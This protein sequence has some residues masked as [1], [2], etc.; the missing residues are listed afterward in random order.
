[1]QSHKLTGQ[2]FVFTLKKEWITLLLWLIGL[3]AYVIIGVVA[4]IEIYGEPAELEA[5]AMAMQNPAMEALF[6]KAIGMD[7]FTV[8]ALYTQS[9]TIIGFV[10]IALMSILLVV[11]N[12][13]GEEEDGTLELIQALPV[14]RLAHT[15]ATIILLLATNTVLAIISSVLLLLLGDASMTLHG[16][17]LTGAMYGISGILFGAVALIT[18]QLSSNTRGSMM[19]AFSVLG[20]AYILRIIG[21]A[22]LT[23]LSWISP[24][25]LLYRSE[26]FASNNWLPIYIGLLVTVLLLIT[27]LWL[28]KHRDIGAGLLPDRPG[29]TRASSLLQT[30]L[31]FVFILIKVPL[32]AW[33]AAMFLLGVSYGSILEDVQDLLSGNEIIEQILASDPSIGLVEQYMSMILA[34]MAMITTIAGLQVFLRIRAEEKKQRLESVVAGNRSRQTVISGFTLTA[35]LSMFW[36]QLVQSLAFGGAALAT[37]Y[38]IELLDVL[39]TGMAYIPAMLIM[40]GVAVILFGWIPKTTPIIW[41]YHGYAFILLY[42]G[43]LFDIPAAFNRLSPFYHVPALPSEEWSWEVTVTLSVVALVLIAIGTVGF[44]QRDIN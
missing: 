25:G 31:G 24:L 10:L 12:T 4:F 22:G 2:M 1:M 14:G 35:V 43:D 3:A 8:G 44:R 7:N 23:V 34:V 40:L 29:K 36:L 20:G 33:S 37:G 5:M 30:S 18:S 42:F 27:A 26:P 9:M 38:D 13:R 15:N 19:L 39:L 28:K 21:D 11:R 6:G 41:L 17:I 16:A 32:I